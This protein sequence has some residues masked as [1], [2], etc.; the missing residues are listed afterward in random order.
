MPAFVLAC[1]NVYIWYKWSY[2]CPF[3]CL[4]PDWIVTSDNELRPLA[5]SKYAALT[6]TAKKNFRNR[7]SPHFHLSMQAKNNPCLS[8][9]TIASMRVLIRLPFSY[10]DIVNEW[11]RK[12]LRY[13]LGLSWP[14]AM[15]VESKDLTFSTSYYEVHIH[16]YFSNFTGL[17]PVW[18][19]KVQGPQNIRGLIRSIWFAADLINH[20]R[21]TSCYKS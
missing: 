8:F 5:I 2:L 6:V 17:E 20:S 13:Q 9:K 16:Q 1:T 10:K 15:S 14:L 18:E 11:H 4:K 12:T 21:G 7:F 3:L 19:C